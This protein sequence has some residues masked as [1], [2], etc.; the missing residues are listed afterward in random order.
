MASR[1]R[2]QRGR[3]VEKLRFFHILLIYVK[4]L[5][6]NE[7]PYQSLELQTSKEGHKA[8]KAQQFEFRLSTWASAPHPTK[9][10]DFL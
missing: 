10:T 6:F 8:V 7:L 9:K 3:S 1:A 4:K 2:G 5:R